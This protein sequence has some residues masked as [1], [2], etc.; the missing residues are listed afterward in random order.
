MPRRGVGGRHC[1]ARAGRRGIRDP[2]A[3]VPSALST[4]RA[5]RH[6]PVCNAARSFGTPGVGLA[7]MPRRGGRGRLCRTTEFRPWAT[8]GRSA[9]LRNAPALRRASRP[10]V[11]PC[12][13]QS[14]APGGA[15]RRVGLGFGYPPRKSRAPCPM[16][17]H[18]VPRPFAMPL[19]AL[20]P[21]GW[22]YPGRPVGVVGFAAAAR[23]RPARGR[24]AHV[25]RIQPPARL[26]CRSVPWNPRGGTYGDA[27]P[28]W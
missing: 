26:Q 15:Q 2:A 1:L 21:P 8:C 4:G 24:A 5:S 13:R 19:G 18:P 7:G 14:A 11:G 27:P 6:P 16:D 3:Q 10:S 25:T 20:E 28:G 23:P 22:G 12:V 17:A 9:P